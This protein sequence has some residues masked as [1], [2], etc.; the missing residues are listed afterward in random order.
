MEFY[1]LIAKGKSHKNYRG[2][3]PVS[4]ADK[5][6]LKVVARRPREYGRRTEHAP[7]DHKCYVCYVPT[8]V[9]RLQEL[10]WKTSVP[11]F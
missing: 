2:H 6:L 1:R 9:N 8:V 7:I 5:V 3:S 11:V 10:G 4:H